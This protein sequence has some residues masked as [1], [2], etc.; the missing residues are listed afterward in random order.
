MEPSLSTPATHQRK[1]SFTTTP[2]S[3]T[4]TQNVP[5][6][7]QTPMTVRKASLLSSTS[8]HSSAQNDRIS[9][10]QSVIQLIGQLLSFSNMFHRPNFMFFAFGI[11]FMRTS[12]VFNFYYYLSLTSTGSPVNWLTIIECSRFFSRC[13]SRW[14][15][16][17]DAI[18]DSTC[19]RIS[20]GS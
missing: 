4:K 5:S 11:S 3:A 14:K 19:H 1:P 2:K 12:S 16:R 18:P 6:Q 7:P 9:L 8:G 10:S 17:N 13:S 15:R 20:Q